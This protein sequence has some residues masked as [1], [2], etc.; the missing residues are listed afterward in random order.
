MRNISENEFELGPVIQEEISLK[1]E[2]FCN[3]S[4]GHY[5]KHFCKYI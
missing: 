3:F 4:R 5:Q 2:P 1:L